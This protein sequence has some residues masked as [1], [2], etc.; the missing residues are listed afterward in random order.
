MEGHLRLSRVF[1][2]LTV[3]LLLLSLCA[4]IT[5]VPR[6]EETDGGET[7]ALTESESTPS[8]SEGVTEK[9]PDTGVETDSKGFPNPPSDDQTKRY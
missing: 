6:G 3:L 1:W 2:V 9:S 7:A 4:C 5:Y 8:D